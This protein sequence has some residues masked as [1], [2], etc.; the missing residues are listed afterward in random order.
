MRACEERTEDA[1]SVLKA[2][3]ENVSLQSVLVAS[4]REIS[5]VDYCAYYLLSPFMVFC[6]EVGVFIALAIHSVDGRNRKSGCLLY[7]NAE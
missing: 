1:R 2:I 3:G 6:F 4:K 7:A 5:V